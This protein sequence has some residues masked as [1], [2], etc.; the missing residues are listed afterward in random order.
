MLSALLTILIVWLLGFVL[1]DIGRIEGPDYSAIRE[2]YV[3]AGLRSRAEDLQR[4]IGELETRVARQE[5]LQTDLQR[6]MDNAR[7]TMQQMMELQRLSLEQQAPPTETEKEALATAQQRFLEAQDRFEAANAEIAASNETRFRLRQ[8]L[9]GV[10]ETI[11]TQEE[12]AREEYQ[13]QRRTHELEVASLQLVF[14]VPLFL[15]SA[16]LFWRYRASAYRSILLALLAA[17]FWK[18]GRV[19]FDH[20][21]REF[22]KYI[23]IAAAIGIVLFFLFW[24]LRKA[25]RPGRDVLLARYRE[26]YRAHLCPICA[27]PIARGPL[28]FALWTRKG[29]RVAT[30][31]AEAASIPGPAAETPYACP[32]CGTTLFALCGRCESPRHSLLPYCEH[33]GDRSGDGAAVVTS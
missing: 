11:A 28:R 27:F 19:M 21:P 31:T 14:I 6:S 25:V 4:Q 9:R 13:A 29:P 12:P 33:C 8:E 20:F 22:F 17:S 16:W 10:Q 5:E 15:L 7:E 24:L 23:A 30:S 3:E 32:S 2:Q 26:A 18:L 1:R